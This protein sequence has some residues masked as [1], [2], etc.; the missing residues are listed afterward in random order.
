MFD[1]R[2][3]ILKAEPK[4]LAAFLEIDPGVGRLWRPNEL[5]AIFQHQLAAPVQ[6]DLAQGRAGNGPVLPPP[7]AEIQTFG[8]LFHHPKP[9]IELLK[10][11]KEFAKAH[12]DHPAST[13]PG[14]I[15]TVLYYS[16]ILVARLRCGVGISALSDEELRTGLEWALGQSWVD[17]RMKSLFHECASILVLGGETA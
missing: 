6:L 8:Q 13:L 5:A 9:P 1:R 2:E 11:V 7:F 14:E 3:H 15:A 12:R 16:S 17:E 4:R 10:A